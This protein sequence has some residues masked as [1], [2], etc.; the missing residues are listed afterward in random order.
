MSAPA[1]R[2]RDVA[3]DEGDQTRRAKERRTELVVGKIEAQLCAGFNK[4]HSTQVLLGQAKANIEMVGGLVC[5]QKEQ[6]QHIVSQLH[7]ARKGPANNIHLTVVAEA[8]HQKYEMAM[9]DQIHELSKVE[10]ALD[11]AHQVIAENN[12]KTNGPWPPLPP[13]RAR[14]N[15]G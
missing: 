4:L 7:A 15:Q 3:Q 13:I 2:G 5:R 14:P 9:Y 11:S 10:E 1:K 12:E 8:A 6:L